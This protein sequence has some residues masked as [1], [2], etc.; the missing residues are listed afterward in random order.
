MHFFDGGNY[1]I[2]R[3][4]SGNITTC[5]NLSS[6]TFAVAFFLIEKSMS[7]SV[8][9]ENGHTF[10]TITFISGQYNSGSSFFEGGTY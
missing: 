8:F 10:L 4:G 1:A 2:K 5:R 9:D 6:H 3:K 7:T